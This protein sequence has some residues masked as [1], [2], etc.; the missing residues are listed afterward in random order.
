MQTSAV[1]VSKLRHHHR[2]GEKRKCPPALVVSC[3]KEI[4]FLGRRRP[5]LWLW[6]LLQGFFRVYDV[7]P[8][9]AIDVPAA[10][11]ILE[12]F[13]QRCKDAGIVTDEI[14]RHMPTR[15]RKR[16][17]SEGDEVWARKGGN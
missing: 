7:M 6:C 11:S 5:N 16:F 1:L 3:P 10:Y 12:R 9:F 15:G 2:P 4:E 14:V 17:V 13:T 8:E